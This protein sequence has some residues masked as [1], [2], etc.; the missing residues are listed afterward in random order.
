MN[1]VITKIKKCIR[2]YKSQNKWDRRTN[3]WHGW[4]SGENYCPWT[5]KKKRKEKNEKKWRKSERPPGQYQVLQHAFTLQGSQRGE[6]ERDKET[7]KIFE[8]IITGNFA[9]IRKETV[10]QVQKVQRSPYR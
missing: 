8:M 7:E 4:H 5:V 1:N 9:N 6:K 3:K 2:K 10:I